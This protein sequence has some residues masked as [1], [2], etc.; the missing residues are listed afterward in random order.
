[1]NMEEAFRLLTLQ[2]I[3]EAILGLHHDE[4]DQVRCGCPT[5]AASAPESDI[6]SRVSCPATPTPVTPPNVV[7]VRPQVFPQLYL[8][9]M[10]EAILR[11]LALFMSGDTKHILAEIRGCPHRCSRSCTCR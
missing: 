3:G 4:C 1:M 5:A 2:V 11:V 8:P 6:E 7:L 10:E 9:V